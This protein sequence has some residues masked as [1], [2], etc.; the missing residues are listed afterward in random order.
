MSV[1]D[2][3]EKQRRAIR[4]MVEAFER[5]GVNTFLFYAVYGNGKTG[6]HFECQPEEFVEIGR[7][8]L[9][10]LAGEGLI[11]LV[12]LPGHDGFLTGSIRQSA[13]DAVR[14]EFER[15]T[16]ATTG[17]VQNFYAPVGAVHTGRGN[18]AISKQFVGLPPSEVSNLIRSMR[19]ALST[20]PVD[21]ATEAK[22]HLDALETELKNQ[23]PHQAR[24]KS[25]LLSLWSVTGNVASFASSLTAIAQAYG[26]SP[27]TL[28]R[29]TPGV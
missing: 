18:I 26:V 22:E 14:N 8:D 29:L 24:I 1:Y 3:L 17:S 12:A 25:F 7:T 5:S 15:P 23:V 20:L 21:G 27:E 16:L 9:E 11:K 10:V 19:D 28:K 4:E 6:V 13:I 2:L